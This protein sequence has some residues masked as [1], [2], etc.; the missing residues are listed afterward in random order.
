[1]TVTRFSNE[2]E[3]IKK[4]KVK[5]KIAVPSKSS[6]YIYEFN[7]FDNFIEFCT[8][9]S[10]N[11]SNSTYLKLKKSSLYKYNS[12]YYLI[13]NVIN[14]T[15][16]KFK[17]IHCSTIEFAKYITNSDLFE[18]KLFEYGT[19]VFKTNAIGKCIKEFLN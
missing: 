1:M 16:D 2:V 3:Q 5:R 14:I 19:P 11:I 7:N 9:F 4:P 17:F 15:L 18:R 13:L 12:K 6:I 10:Q 8:Y